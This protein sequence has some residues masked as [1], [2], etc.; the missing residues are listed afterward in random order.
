M[1]NENTLDAPTGSVKKMKNETPYPLLALK[2]I[3]DK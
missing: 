2:Y 1:I 3:Q